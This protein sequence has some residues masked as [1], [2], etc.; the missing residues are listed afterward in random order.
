MS[1]RIVD[2]LGITWAEG[3]LTVLTATAVYLLM[4]VLSRTFGQRQFASWGTYDLAFVFAI[5]SIVGRVILVRVSLA[6]AA[7]GLVTLF[8]L[9][10]ATTWLHH[11]APVAHRLIQNRPILL[12]ADGELLHDQLRRARVSVQEVHQ[13]LRLQG[14][15]DLE[16]VRAVVLERNGVLSV[17]A[18]DARLS[19]E[20]FAQVDGRQWLLDGHQH[21]SAR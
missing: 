16:R 17:I 11:N 8:A 3:G 2:Q 19:R 20:V 14:H 12:V 4:I 5:G 7:V 6:T 15:G 9:H 1:D 21:R 18:D 13:A 10:G